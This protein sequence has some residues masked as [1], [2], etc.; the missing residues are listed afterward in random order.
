MDDGKNNRRI[1]LVLKLFNS[2][3]SQDERAELRELEDEADRYVDKAVE[4]QYSELTK[5]FD[6][7]D[8]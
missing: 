3:L 8:V 4:D 6:K 7:Y 2:N 5:L 1:E